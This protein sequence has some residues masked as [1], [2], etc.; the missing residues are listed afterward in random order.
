VSEPKGLLL[1]TMEPSPADEQ[2]FHD[3]YDSEHVPERAGVPGFLTAARYVCLDGWPRFVGIYDLEHVGVLH[4]DGYKAI[5][6]ERFSP[7]SKRILNR[8][9]GVYRVEGTQVYPGHAVTGERGTPARLIL[10]RFRDRSDS[11][12]PVIIRGLEATYGG[13]Q[14]LLQFR[15]FSSAY[16]DGH[17]DFIALIE[18]RA[19]TMM[20]ELDLAAFGMNADYIDIINTYTRY[21]SRGRLHGVFGR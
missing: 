21:W 8:V 1:V 9:R 20:P 5:S 19:T 7:W 12:V 3:W 2:E 17:V 10:L 16:D 11:D 15:L 14:S 6:G 4:E 13:R 18:L